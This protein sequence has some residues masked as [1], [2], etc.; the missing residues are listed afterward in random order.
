MSGKQVRVAGGVVTED[1]LAGLLGR[2]E[3]RPVK[4]RSIGLLAGDRGARAPKA[5]GYGVPLLVTYT[6]GGEERRVVFRTQGANWFGHDR[7]SDRA[8]L[9][10]L[11]ADTYGDQ[12]N[13]VQV[14]E[15]GAMRS[16]SL[17]PLTG[18]DELYLVTSYAGGE[19]YATDLRRVES[20]GQSS[21]LDQERAATLARHIALLHRTRPPDARDESYVRAARDLVGSGEGIFGIVDSYPIQSPCRPKLNRIEE[22][23]LRWRRKLRDDHTARLRRTHGDFHPYN[24][25]FREGCDFTLLDA[26]RGGLGDPADDLAAMSVNFIA[27]AFRARGSWKHGFGPL[28]STFFTTY[29]ELTGDHAVLEVFPPF[30]A[31]RALVLASPTWYPHASERSRE[32]LLELAIRWLEAEPFNPA[33]IGALVDP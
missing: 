25:L 10:L 6:A 12:P 7:R 33:N 32:Q 15:V 9:T 4:V 17:V 30:F 3:A 26:S 23:S 5:V 19:L 27:P 29:L 13:H 24:V 11:A 22:L 18:A 2:I 20:S 16:G 14:L 31:W 1:A 28:W 8:C 21:P